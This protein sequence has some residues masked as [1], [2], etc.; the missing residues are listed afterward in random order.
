MENMVAK[1][2]WKS[3][4]SEFSLWN[5]DFFITFNIVDIDTV[6]DEITVA[7]SKEGKLSVCTYDL[8]SDGSERLFFE[9]GAF[10]ERIAVD[11]FEIIGED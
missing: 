4:L 10:F 8:K 11:D 3:Y 9:Y 6:R 1:E 7:V 2:S 5:G